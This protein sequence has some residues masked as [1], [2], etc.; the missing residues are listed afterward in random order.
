[1]TQLNRLSTIGLAK[2]TVVNTYLVPTVWIPVTKMDF[3]DV[4][5]EIK[6][7]S[8]R[9]NDTL[10]QG[11]YQGVVHGEWTIDLLGYPD[12]LGHFLR[13]M[14]G[15]DTVTAGVST[16]LSSAAAQNATTIS[17]AASIAPNTYINIDTGVSQEYALVTA[18]S[19]VGPYTLTVTTVQ[20]QT[21]GLT[22]SHLSAAAV[23]GT[24]SH[25]FKQSTATSSK[26]TYSFTVYDT[27]Q[28]LSYS[29]A[30]MD[31]LQ[32]KIDPKGA[33]SLVTK[34]KSFP[35]VAAASGTPTFT[36]L[37]PILGW[38]WNM[39]NA[40]AA[41]TRG[42]TYDLTAKRTADPIHS[43]DGVQAPR[44]IFQGALDVTATY[45][46]IFENQTD[47][48]LYLAY[49]QQP[50][51]A[52]LQAPVAKGGSALT[53]TMSKTGFHKGKRDWTNYVEATFSL[54]GIYNTTD[55]GAVQAT[56][57]NFITTAY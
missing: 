56:L 40:G 25:L 28:W 3:E 21:V 1:M 30:V 26:A 34:Y 37:D 5:T 12:L 20:G 9:A 43:S 57:S 14:I 32:F 23:V 53:L 31:D 55:G 36:S 17:T 52:T 45:K 6:D 42:L 13:G 29:G 44:E 2:E 48:N 7:E 35:G 22:K 50:V 49:T 27:T 19:G 24:T 54:Q 46:A 47:L 16:T 18:V 38:E 4:Y 15:P 33:V 10:M 39:T 11:L 41:S 51:T 8:Y